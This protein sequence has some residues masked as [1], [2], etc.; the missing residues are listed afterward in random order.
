MIKYSIYISGTTV[1]GLLDTFKQCKLDVSMFPMH[2]TW[3]GKL[4]YGTLIVHLGDGSTA[5][6]IKALA[7]DLKASFEQARVVVTSERINMEI[8]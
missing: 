1:N 3:Q 2:G 4:E 7:C 6:L 8:I 5:P